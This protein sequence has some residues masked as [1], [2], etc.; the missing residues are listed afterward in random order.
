LISK[1]EQVKIIQERGI[2]FTS[3]PACYDRKSGVQIKKKFA[4]VFSIPAEIFAGVGSPCCNVEN[5]EVITSGTTRLEPGS[6]TDRYKI[7][8]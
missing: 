8:G 6:Y 5:N 3:F 1:K 7:R 4:S 2:V